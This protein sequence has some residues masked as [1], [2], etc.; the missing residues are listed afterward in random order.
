MQTAVQ[1]T[2]G[3]ASQAQITI[4]DEPTNGLDAHFRKLFYQVLLDSYEENPR[5]I[6]LSSHHIDEIEPLCEK[7]AVVHDK[8]VTMHIPVEQ[9][10]MQGIVLTGPSAA[11]EAVTKK[12]LKLL[13]R[14]KSV[15]N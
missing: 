11:I 1:L 3:L 5:F 7:I 8:R 10:Q 13:R 12:T 4:M 14:R 2:I 15:S 6:L 9:L